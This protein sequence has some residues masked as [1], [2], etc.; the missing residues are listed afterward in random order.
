MANA[1]S[2]VVDALAAASDGAIAEDV[3]D[4]L[5]AGGD[6][7]LDTLNLTSLKRFEIIMRIEEVFAIE[8]DDDEVMEQESIASLI[9]MVEA[10][11]QSA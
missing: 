8:V 2:V 4:G 1:R 10:K 5:R 9:A 3:L 6:I 11:R 7:A